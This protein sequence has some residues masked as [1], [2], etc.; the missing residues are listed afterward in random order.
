MDIEEE[1]V[2]YDKVYF[3]RCNETQL[4]FFV[5]A[6]LVGSGKLYERLEENE[7]YY[8]PQ[9]WEHDVAITDLRD[10]KNVLEVGCARGSFV[11]RLITELGIDAS[12]LELNSRAVEHANKNNL[13]VFQRDL[14]DFANEFEGTFDA[15]CSFQVLEHV[16]NPKVFIA[17]LV[18]LL[19]PGGK[20]ILGVPNSE[21]FIQHSDSV[22]N[23]PPHHMT[24]WYR[25]TFEQL[26]SIF[27]LSVES[28]RFEPLAEYMAE[29]YTSVQVRRMPEFF[30]LYYVGS[31]I[32]Y[33]VGLPILRRSKMLRQRIAGHTL[34]SCLRKNPF[35]S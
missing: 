21:S 20:L 19:K 2:G 16:I 30:P 10:C 23:K 15:V 7:W 4:K 28:I 32:A 33:H 25:A 6:G 9:K 29:F 34:Y 26:P 31:R 14:Q 27:P 18:R 24:R 13:P 5:P 11:Q 3:Y 35:L 8:M 12:G 1:V 22:L 17:D